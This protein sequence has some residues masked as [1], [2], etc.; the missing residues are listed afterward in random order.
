[1]PLPGAGVEVLNRYARICL[2]DGQE[3]LSNIFTV[4]AELLKP[5]GED[6]AGKGDGK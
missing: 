3:F 2:F 1:V 5:S 4:K 6:F